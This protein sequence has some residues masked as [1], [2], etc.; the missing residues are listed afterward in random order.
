MTSFAPGTTTTVLT[1]DGEKRQL[2]EEES[3]Q[4]VE[5]NPA[6]L[7]ANIDDLVNISDLNEMS[8]L[9][10]LRNRFRQNS[11][12]KL[13]SLLKSVAV[14]ISVTRPNGMTFLPL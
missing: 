3:A 6:S 10:I 1:E 12:C 2:S 8:I 9:H 5:C 4:V 14:A 7:D 13:K 11:I